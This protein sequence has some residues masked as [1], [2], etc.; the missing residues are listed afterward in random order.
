MS[1]RVQT[2]TPPAPIVVT[3]PS[4]DGQ[5]GGKGKPGSSGIPEPYANRGSLIM[6]TT[7]IAA[8]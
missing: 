1:E 7:F 5:G 6:N 8:A 3:T 2:A 4:V